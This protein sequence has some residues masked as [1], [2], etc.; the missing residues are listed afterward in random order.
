MM[1]KVPLPF[2]N[3]QLDCCRIYHWKSSFIP[4]SAWNSGEHKLVRQTNYKVC[5]I[6][7]WRLQILWSRYSLSDSQGV[8][9]NSVFVGLIDLGWVL[10]TQPKRSQVPQSTCCSVCSEFQGMFSLAVVTFLFSELKIS[11]YN[12][13]TAFR[14]PSDFI[15]AWELGCFISDTL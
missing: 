3:E 6:T 14:S 9:E 2:L 13:M 5:P 12:P 15:N 10:L 8:A 1:T 4:V 7:K 11:W